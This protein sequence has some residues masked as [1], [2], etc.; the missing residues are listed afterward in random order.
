MSKSDDMVIATE[1]LRSITMTGHYA[2]WVSSQ[3]LLPSFVCFGAALC[4][5]LRSC[6]ASELP[7]QL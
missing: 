7:L 1:K 6:L 2:F 3:Y 4:L 5:A